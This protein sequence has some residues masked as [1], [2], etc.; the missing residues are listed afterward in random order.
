VASVT[1]AGA[2][3][4]P[5]ALDLYRAALRNGRTWLTPARQ[6]RL[7]ILIELLL[8]AS[9]IVV[10]T[11]DVSRPGLLGWT[12]L[13]GVVCVVAPASGLTA[14]VAIVP[15]SEWLLLDR[16]TGI[17]ILI[18]PLLGL[19]VLLRL[20]VGR[21]WQRPDLVTVLVIAVLVGTGFAVALAT[22]RFGSE[23][24]FRAVVYWLAGPGGGLIVLLVARHSARAGNLR[25]LIV[26][27]A[28]IAIAA[29]ASLIDFINP[30]VI[31]NGGL[32]WLVRPTVDLTRL[33]GIIPAPN[34]VA[35]LFM[36]GTAVM[37]VIL[38]FGRRAG[39]DWRRFLLLAPIAWCAVAI[40]FTY[41]RTGI[42]A[43]F[44]LAVLYGTWWRRRIGL[45]IL[46]VGLA[47]AVVAVP[48]YL[49]YRAS[50]IGSGAVSASGGLL[51]LSDVERL[52]A[53]GSA[54]RMWLDSPLIGSG[55]LAFKQ[56]HAAYG[57][58]NI[59]APHNEFLRLMAEDGILVAV[60]FIALCIVLGIHLWR[61]RGVIALASLGAL[62]SLLA[63]ASY[64][65]P[66]GY[67]QVVVPIFAIVGCGLARPYIEDRLSPATD[68][69]V[70]LEH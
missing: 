35:A 24:G 53:W 21:S 10:R 51:T 2:G 44:L 20:A 31:R 23:V 69:M 43:L 47:V 36:A 7:A 19:G 25:P 64:N 60:A 26:A 16:D 9:Y 28:S 22:S 66:F 40:W 62:V 68:G 6:D 3:T 50:T 15:F 33:T 41:S 61:A 30:D 45:T 17:K 58:V 14:L 63:A 46:A 1:L 55:T 49:Q 70:P 8:I 57:S 4:S 48:V 34:A 56:V 27:T 32:N 37:V 29:L 67:V 11:A 42:L 12:L 18:P 5:S 52:D 38:V 54:W 39:L 59:A 13:L 65:N